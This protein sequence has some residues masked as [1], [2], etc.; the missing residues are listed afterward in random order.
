MATTVQAPV[1]DSPLPFGDPQLAAELAD[2]FHLVAECWSRGLCVPEEL[3][4]EVDRLLDCVE[5]SQTR[6]REVA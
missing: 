4:D 1:A 5:H 2:V 3:L 6:R